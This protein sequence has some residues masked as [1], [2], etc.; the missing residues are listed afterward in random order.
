MACTGLKWGLGRGKTRQRKEEQAEMWKAKGKPSTHTFFP[1]LATV[2][3]TQGNSE[4]HS[5]RGS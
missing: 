4:L 2:G 1:C 3:S 5:V